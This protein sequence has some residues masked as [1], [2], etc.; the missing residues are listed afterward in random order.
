MRL[1][2]LRSDLL[3]YIV[4][5]DYQPGDKLPTLSDISDELGVSVAKTREQ[6]EVARAFGVVEVKPGRGSVV[7]SYDFTPAMRLSALYAIGHDP[8]LFEALS[9]TRNALE[10]FF[11]EQAVSLLDEKDFAHL[12][13][14]I[15]QARKQLNR[16]PIVVPSEEHRQFHLSIFAKLSNPFV[17][18]VLETYWDAY[19]A[20][21]LNLFAE[22]S[23]HRGVWDYH[24]RIVEALEAGDFEEAKAV[25]V[26]HMALLRHREP[27]TAK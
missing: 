17:S 1:K 3:R 7:Q 12:R 22:L 14:L 18:G 19:D 8:A 15:A 5:R 6:L 2:D 27:G 13:E 21:G 24:E 10:T 11:W 16:T 4:E 20:F 26:E 25:L 23:Y 9:E